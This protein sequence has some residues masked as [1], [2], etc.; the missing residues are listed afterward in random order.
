MTSRV[1]I[2]GLTRAV[3]IE[4]AIECGADMLG[5][6]VEAT[7][8]RRLSVEQATRLSMPVRGILPRVAV[9]VNAD[10]DLMAQIASEM[11]PDYIQFHGDE[12]PTR[13]ANIGRALGIKTIKA[14]P[15]ATQDD[16]I[17]AQAFYDKTDIILFDAKPPKGEIV[18]GGHGVTFD[19]GLIGKNHTP[20]IFALAGGL[21]PNNI[22][23]ARRR[24]RA[25]LFDLS[26]GVEH[27]PGIKDHQLLAN[28]IEKLRS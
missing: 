5:F 15:I 6:I 26:S 14:I 16:M 20:D 1:K 18:R 9:T 23:D 11:K 22:R 27:A 7:S 25:S 10:N 19:W 12:T 3:D 2:C 4:A 28:F 13:V 21:R 8:P 17:H 24:T